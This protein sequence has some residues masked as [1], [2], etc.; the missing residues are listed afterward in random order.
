MW[1]AI[2]PVMAAGVLVAHAL[3]YRLTGT[4]PGPFHAYLDHSPQLLLVLAVAGLAFGGLA[5]R[6][7]IPAASSFPVAALATF[8]VQ[9]HGERFVSRL[10][11]LKERSLDEMIEAGSVLCGSSESVVAQ[12]RRIRDDL[13]NG[14]FNLNLKIGNIPDAVV[15]RGMELFRDRVLPRAREL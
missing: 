15:H 8:V 4:A 3:A 1:L 12:M 6:L 5:A 11:T 10:V 9:E 14:H 13:G 7:R 2:S